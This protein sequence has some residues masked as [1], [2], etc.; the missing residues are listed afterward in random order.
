MSPAEFALWEE[1]NGRLWG[2]L[3]SDSPCRDCTPLFH[4]DM[5]DGGMCDGAP[6]PEVRESK[7]V[8]PKP[9]PLDGSKRDYWRLRR[10]ESRERARAGA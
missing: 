10:R 3:K 8:G 7:R 6:L 5:L 1:V 9:V 4:A 2:V